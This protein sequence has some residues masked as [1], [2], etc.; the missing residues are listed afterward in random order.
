VLEVRSNED[1]LS[2]VALYWRTLGVGEAELPVAAVAQVATDPSHRGLG[3]ATALVSASHSVARA[4]GLEWA[5]L[6]G[7]STLYMRLGYRH[8]EETTEPDLLV[9]PLVD[10]TEWPSGPVDT[11]G[12]W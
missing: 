1:V 5:A 6:F 3:L 11:R 2:H 8:P 7:V 12:K 4:H 10:G 9:C